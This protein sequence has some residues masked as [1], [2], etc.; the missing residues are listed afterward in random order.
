MDDAACLWY[1]PDDFFPTIKKKV[2]EVKKICGQ[3]NVRIKCLAW[4]MA[5]EQDDQRR[6]GIAGG[7]TPSERSQLQAI[8]DQHMKEREVA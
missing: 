3:C 1:P 7:L 2:D 4:A 6:H 8:M 5:G